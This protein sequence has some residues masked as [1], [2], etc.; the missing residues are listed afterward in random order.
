MA[1][2]TVRRSTSDPPVAPRRPGAAAR[3]RSPR[4][5]SCGRGEPAGIALVWGVQCLLV[6]PFVAWLALRELG[7]SPFW[8]AGRIAPAAVATSAIVPAVLLAQVTLADISATLRLIGAAAT[9]A[10]VYLPVALLALDARLPSALRPEPASGR[11]FG[12]GRA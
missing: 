5:W 2:Q 11:A 8:L 6:T 9:G 10:M 4:W 3:R 1:A 7:R 12:P